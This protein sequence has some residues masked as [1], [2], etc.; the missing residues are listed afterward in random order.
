M[1]LVST[2]ANYLDIQFFSGRILILS[3]KSSRF[4]FQGSKY[5]Y[6]KYHSLGSCSTVKPLLNHVVFAFSQCRLIISVRQRNLDISMYCMRDVTEISKSTNFDGGNYTVELNMIII[7]NT[8]S[9]E[10]FVIFS[11]FGKVISKPIFFHRL[12]Q[13]S[14]C[15]QVQTLKLLSFKDFNF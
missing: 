2:K 3:K 7:K 15:L 4:H 5:A 9:A 8:P 11:N 12:W 6:E 13:T 1:S 14:L 10:S